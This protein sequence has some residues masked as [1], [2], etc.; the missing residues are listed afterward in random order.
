MRPSE[1]GCQIA[2][3]AKRCNE[4]FG[5]SV[6]QLSVVDRSDPEDARV[7]TDF[8]NEYTF[9][10]LRP[11]ADYDLRIQVS[12]NLTTIDDELSSSV[13][14]YSFRTLSASKYKY[15]SAEKV[16]LGQFEV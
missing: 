6:Y 9:S 2:W 15:N 16:G 14:S 12:R 1:T 3:E 5:P 11:F 4:T 7:Q 8:G 10:D 13:L